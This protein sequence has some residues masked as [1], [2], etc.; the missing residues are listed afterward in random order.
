MKQSTLS[1]LFVLFGIFNSLITAESTRLFLNAQANSGM[2][3][4]ASGDF[5]FFSNLFGGSSLTELPD[6]SH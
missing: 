4:Q 1:F 2:K 3:V 6:I 5:S